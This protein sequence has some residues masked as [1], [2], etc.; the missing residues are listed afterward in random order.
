MVLRVLIVGGSG[1]IGSQLANFLSAQGQ[2]VK[3]YSRTCKTCTDKLSGIEYLY[4][5]F[6]NQ[7]LLK[8][9]LKNIDVVYQMVSTTIPSTSN[10]N[11]VEDVA[12]NVIN[13]IS[14][15]Q[16]CV[17]ASVK[18]VI[19]P[20]SGGTIYGIPQHIPI[21]ET[22]P[23]EPIS[24]YGITKLTIEKYLFLFHHLYG[25]DYTILR[26][27][28][29]YGYGQNPTRKVGAITIF[30][31]LIMR[32]LPI[33][34]WGNGEIIRDYVYISD[35][36]RALYAAQATD[37]EQK[38]FNIGSGV[39]TSLIE[40]IEYFKEYIPQKSFEVQYIDSRTFD[41]PINI[42][43]ISNANQVLNW[44]PTISLQKG[45]KLTWEWLKLWHSQNQK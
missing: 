34:I 30:L 25:L 37:I 15:L 3:I 16:Y 19:F 4:G 42:L 5:D 2:S 26:I 8:K 39:G 28:N 40:L 45:I 9:A 31:D 10:Q 20:S 33:R 38:I 36:S 35:V 21:P 18:K 44:Q 43:D 13:M 23:T 7:Y 11:P 1:F 29:P 32:N 14:F 41:V 6:S 22:H 24:S 27:A 17:D 12:D